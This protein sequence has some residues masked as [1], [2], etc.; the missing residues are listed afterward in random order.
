MRVIIISN[1]RYTFILLQ[2]EIMILYCLEIVLRDIMIDVDQI[3]NLNCIKYYTI[4]I[5]S[6]IAVEIQL[7][8]ICF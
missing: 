1:S 7:E 6:H 5:F 8:I 2:T 3:C 4:M